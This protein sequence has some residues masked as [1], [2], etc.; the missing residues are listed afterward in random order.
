MSKRR[1]E[2]IHEETTK[3]A[4][5]TSVV[6]IV[7]NETGVQYL[8]SGGA[9]LN[10]GGMTPLLDKDGKPILAVPNK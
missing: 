3:S 8:C 7:D 10:T 2:V 5:V 4:V 9:V 1:F 6:V